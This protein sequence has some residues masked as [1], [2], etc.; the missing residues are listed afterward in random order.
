LIEVVIAMGIAAMV[1]SGIILG[2]TTSCQRV[3]WASYDL[4]AQNLAQQ[5]IE[6]ARAAQWD[7]LAPTPV[8]FC[9]QSNF[10]PATNILDI[11]ISGTNVTRA[12]TTWTITNVGTSNYPLKMIRV[13]CAWRYQNV[14]RAATFFTNT[15][16]TLR[17]PDQ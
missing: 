2:F 16:A 3:E 9:V 4:A 10:P 13:D 14:G 8:D 17:S 12:V 6:Q 5:G 1:F 11:P 7:P 15:V